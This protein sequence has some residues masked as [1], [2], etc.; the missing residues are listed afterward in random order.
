MRPLVLFLWFCFF[1]NGRIYILL[2]ISKF[3]VFS[4]T[5]K[6]SE[7][8]LIEV[9]GAHAALVLRSDRYE[10]AKHR[11]TYIHPVVLLFTVLLCLPINHK[12]RDGLE[13]DVADLGE[14]MALNR[15]TFGG[16]TSV[17]KADA[18][19]GCRSIDEMSTCFK[20][21]RLSQPPTTR[22]RT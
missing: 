13:Q 11:T 21:E 18:S 9:G 17:A 20:T 8:R 4:S 10:Y 6:W 7:G 19:C 15:I 5:V 2:K 16:D 14:G 12:S 1:T 3:F 22:T